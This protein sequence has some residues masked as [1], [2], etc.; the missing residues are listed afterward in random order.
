MA[1][2]RGFEEYRFDRSASAIYESRSLMPVEGEIV[3]VQEV[4]RL[5]NAQELKAAEARYLPAPGPPE[6]G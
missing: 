3:P 4:F 5:Q 2:V 6:A 1:R